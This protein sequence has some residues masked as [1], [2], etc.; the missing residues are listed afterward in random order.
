MSNL[1]V[2]D[3]VVPD[4]EKGYVYNGNM[5]IRVDTFGI[6]TVTATIYIPNFGHAVSLNRAGIHFFPAVQLKKY[7]KPKRGKKR[8]K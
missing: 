4:T 2:G 8:K 5:R 6:R 7:V 3:Q 1:K